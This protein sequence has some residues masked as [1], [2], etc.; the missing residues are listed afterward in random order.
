MNQERIYQVLLS[1]HVT[2]KT[3]LSS[4][5]N[6]VV[7][8]VLKNST[9][10]EIKKAV[11]KLFD[12]KVKSISTSVV[13]GKTKRFGRALGVRSDWKKAY[14]TLHEGFDIDIMGAE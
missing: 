1:P 11:E 3:S 4:S 13:K 8:K 14:V 5:E 9:K 7:F 12:V 10:P 2:E 6:Q